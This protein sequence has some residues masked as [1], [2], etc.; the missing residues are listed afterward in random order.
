MASPVEMLSMLQNMQM[1]KERMAMQQQQFAQQ[2]AEYQRLLEAQN[3]IKQAAVSVS[4]LDQQLYAQN[5]GQY[6]DLMSQLVNAN[7]DLRDN[8]VI[9][10]RF[11]GGQ[12][13][14]GNVA[15]LI[16]QLTP[17]KPAPPSDIEGMLRNAMEAAIRAGDVGQANTISGMLGRTSQGKSYGPSSLTDAVGTREGAYLAGMFPEAISDPSAMK[18]ALSYRAEQFKD[19]NK[20]EEYYKGLQRYV[21]TLADQSISNLRVNPQTGQVEGFNEMTQEFQPVT[22]GYGRGASMT[23][24]D[25][26][27]D[28]IAKI[29]YLNDINELNS[30]ARDLWM[31]KL[32]G[33]LQGTWNTMKSA[34]F[35]NPEFQAWKD[36]SA[37]RIILAYGMSGKQIS[38][39]EIQQILGRFLP[40]QY[41]P[42]ENLA[43]REWALSRFVNA[44]IYN[45]L[46]TMEGR[47]VL[48]PE[49]KA[50]MENA[51]QNM[52]DSKVNIFNLANKKV[53]ENEWGI[54]AADGTA[55]E[56]SLK[57]EMKQYPGGQG[58]DLGKKSTEE[59][60][61]ELRKKLGGGQ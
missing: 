24:P 27:A 34:I 59:L 60:L 3:R 25:M 19:P 8:I 38:E 7:T 58:G 2:Q 54:T 37:Q 42:D 48:T 52:T 1:N 30:M 51:K 16:S 43:A 33:P 47:R 4:P 45:N 13:I 32:T 56:N 39:K 53:G 55:I 21:K 61:Q 36:A 26:T 14:E 20:R 12:D 40:T 49:D 31:P 11:G 15:D 29:S 10:D 28:E 18:Q 23:A 57:R 50:L 5:V 35:N 9:P 22:G 46:K 17:I 44:S 41:M 6:D